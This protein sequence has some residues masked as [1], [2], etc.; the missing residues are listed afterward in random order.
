MDP[1]EHAVRARH[2]A[3]ATG[4]TG[5]ALCL[6]ALAWI[7]ATGHQP[8][9]AATLLGAARSIW[10]AL[11]T[12]TYAP[13]KG[14]HDACVL[15]AHSDLGQAAFDAAFGKGKAMS[16]THAVS[17][18]LEEPQPA[19]SR[20]PAADLRAD[21]LTERERQVA[22]LIAQGLSNKQIAAHLV[23]SSRTAE[24]HVRHILN[25]L[26]LDSRIQIATWKEPGSFPDTKPGG[27]S[28]HER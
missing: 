19:S 26:G 20:Q 9:R 4:R 3:L 10:D 18:A 5:I 14:Y 17:Y 23:I 13:W 24:S 12:E 21:G 1:P 6:E 28:A 7:T 11:L 25:K 15:Q 8:Q 16:I 22:A 2:R 27:K